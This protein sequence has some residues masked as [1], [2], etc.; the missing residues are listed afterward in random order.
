MTEKTAYYANLVCY[1]GTREQL[2]AFADGLV[3]AGYEPDYDEKFN[4]WSEGKKYILTYD[5]G[6]FGYF[7][8]SGVSSRYRFSGNQIKEAVA[9]ATEPA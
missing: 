9:V 6:T 4:S 2:E 1:S 3:K 7:S 8:Y 5:D